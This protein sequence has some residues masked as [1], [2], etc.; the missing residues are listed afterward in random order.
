LNGTE[1]P[2]HSELNILNLDEG[3]ATKSGPGRTAAPHKTKIPGNIPAD[4]QEALPNF[5]LYIIQKREKNLNSILWKM[6]KSRALFLC[7][8]NV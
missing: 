3:E 8:L 1:L 5:R 4:F 7:A 6:Q 2:D